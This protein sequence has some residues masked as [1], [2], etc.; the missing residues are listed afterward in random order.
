MTEEIMDRSAE[1]K[2]AG[3]AQASGPADL[4]DL[5]ELV[6]RAFS[7]AAQQQKPEWYRMHGTVLKNRLLD[8]TERAF[9]EEDYGAQ[10]FLGFVKLFDYLLN[11]DLS[12]RPY[13]VELLEPYRSRVGEAATVAS[14]QWI[15]SDLWR[16]TVDYSSL[17]EWLWNPSSGTVVNTDEGP[18]ADGCLPLPTLD[19]AVLGKWRTEFAGE[20]HDALD[21]DERRQVEKWSTQGLRS[22]ALPRHLLRSW[23]A[24]VRDRVEQRL[25]DFFDTHG[26]TPPSDLLSFNEPRR[27]ESELRSFV[28][29]CV[30][31]MSEA[32]LKELSIPTHV[33]MRAHQ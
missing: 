25:V 24:L 16:A 33:A 29:R 18:L 19:P 10:N 31:L 32:E 13:V 22:S 12:V 21:D 30:D 4:G 28:A 20:H 2:M 9:D 27:P 14:G 26:L 3:A 11:T 8:L 23:N 5:E 1:P 17:G 7:K 6:L 15:R